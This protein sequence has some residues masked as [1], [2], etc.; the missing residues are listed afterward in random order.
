MQ[1]ETLEDCKAV[2]C[3][4]PPPPSTSSLSPNERCKQ[5]SDSGP[6]GGSFPRWFWNSQ[7]GNSDSS[8]YGGFL[9]TVTI[10]TLAESKNSKCGRS[11]WVLT[12]HDVLSS[13][14][15]ISC[16]VFWML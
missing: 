13:S 14:W 12:E 7:K 2:K 8:T 10:E 5:S 4:A 1:F 16:A 15:L 11:R 9:S 3:V 6:C